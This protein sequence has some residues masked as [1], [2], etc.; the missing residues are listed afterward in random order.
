MM[1]RVVTGILLV[2]V[3]LTGT[4]VADEQEDFGKT[5]SLMF[6]KKWHKAVK[7]LELFRDKYPDSRMDSKAIF[8]IALC[9]EELG[10]HYRAFDYYTMYLKKGKIRALKEDARIG[11][12]DA[13]FEISKKRDKSYFR[14]I[15]KYLNSSYEQAKYYAAFKLS[16]VKNRK[17]ASKGVPVLK[18]IVRDNEDEELVERA[19][20]ALMRIDP[21]HLK[22]SGMSQSDSK[23]TLIR[24]DIYNKAKKKSTLSLSFPL[25]LGKLMFDSLEEKDQ[26]KIFEGES[27]DSFIKKLLK[28]GEMLKIDSDTD[29]IRVWLE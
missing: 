18:Q 8:Y 10:N 25:A 6:D 11:V 22:D 3:L 21:D 27:A 28:S 1:K 19:R 16:Y 9:N 24:I 13:A 14:Y 2:I 12:I 5:K 20:I 23:F 29:V 17:T 15:E 26:K 4:L 7:A